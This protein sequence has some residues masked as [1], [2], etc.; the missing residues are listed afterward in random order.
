MPSLVGSEMCIRDRICLEECVRIWVEDIKRNKIKI[1]AD[2]PFVRV[3][4]GVF[5][6]FYDLFYFP[7][8]SIYEE[9]EK[10]NDGV[11]KGLDS[12]KEKMATG[13]GRVTDAAKGLLGSV[14]RVSKN[15]V[16]NPII[17]KDQMIGLPGNLIGKFTSLQKKF[18]QTN[19]NK[20]IQY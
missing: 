7:I 13:A 3:F 2:L 17:T 20:T 10:F 4:A 14:W 12:F 11:S 15:A 1:I 19:T 6:G 18:E 16:S 9:E 8:K 5:R